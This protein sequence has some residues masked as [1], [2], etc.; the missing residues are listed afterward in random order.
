MAAFT[1]AANTGATEAEL[2]ARIVQTNLME[3]AVV[4]NTANDLS[5]LI[6]NGAKSVD[7]PRFELGPT[8]RFGDPDDQNPD[9]ETDVSCKTVVLDTDTILLDKWKNLAYA[10][11]DRLK[12]QSSVPLEAELA[13]QAGKDFALYMDSEVVAQ[14]QALP[15]SIVMTGAI[16]S[17]TG[18]ATLSL[19]DITEGRR[20]LDLQNVDKQGRYLIISPSQEKAMLN[21]DNF[22]KADEYGSREALLNGEVGRVFGMP[23]IVSNNMNQDEA[24]MVQKECVAYAIQKNVEFETERHVKTKKTTYSYFAGWGLTTTYGG[25][26]GIRFSLI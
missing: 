1:S 12:I 19:S 10:V 18:N 16:D 23:V 11:P 13:K 3:K 14:Y 5:N 17:V 6:G 26:K 9:G 24:F 7:V 20:Q 15:N 2:I 25:V 22:I 21:I 8:G 4:M